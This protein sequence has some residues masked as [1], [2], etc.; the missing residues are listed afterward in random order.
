MSFCYIY[1]PPRRARYQCLTSSFVCLQEESISAS[2]LVENMTS[3]DQT[4]KFLKDTLVSSHLEHS[5]DR[6]EVLIVTNKDTQNGSPSLSEVSQ[7]DLKEN[8]DIEVSMDGE[9]D[10]EGDISLLSDNINSELIDERP[11]QTNLPI[12][13][14]NL[15][16]SDSICEDLTTSIKNDDNSLTVD[17]AK[18]ENNSDTVSLLPG[19]P[20]SPRLSKKEGENSDNRKRTARLPQIEKLI[21][22]ETKANNIDVYPKKTSERVANTLKGTTFL[23]KANKS[24]RFVDR[25]MYSKSR[26]FKLSSLTENKRVPAKSVAPRR[27]NE[28]KSQG[29]H[30]VHAKPKVTMQSTR[31]STKVT[32]E[33]KKTQQTEESTALLPQKRKDSSPPGKSKQSKLTIT[34]AGD[35][36][37]TDIVPLDNKEEDP[38]QFQ[39]I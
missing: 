39:V 20:R 24:Q 9:C 11:L 22:S 37:D 17:N 19:L 29:L 36:M 12:L 33:L 5:S 27:D 1:P 2:H 23:P 3:T 38:V 35:Q 28:H 32:D 14:M 25:G 16:K 4:T 31:Q 30:V 26:T 6:Y 13:P 10:S 18:I 34:T 21:Q 7:K 15:T 8:E